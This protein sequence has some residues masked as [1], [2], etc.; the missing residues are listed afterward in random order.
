MIILTIIPNKVYK[1]TMMLKELFILTESY[2]REE[3][4]ICIYIYI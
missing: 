4:C 2:E 3:A 1:D